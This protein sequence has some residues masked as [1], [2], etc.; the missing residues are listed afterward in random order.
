MHTHKGPVAQLLVMEAVDLDRS[1]TTG[2]LPKMIAKGYTQILRHLVQKV[3][4]HSEPYSAS[5]HR[6]QQL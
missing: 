1:C 2:E 5:Y 3:S 6:L 4:V